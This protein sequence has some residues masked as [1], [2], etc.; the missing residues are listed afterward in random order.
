MEVANPTIIVCCRIIRIEL[1]G[2]FEIGHRHAGMTEVF[3]SNSPL[4]IGL[5]I[6]RIEPD[7]LIVVLYGAFILEKMS[8]NIGTV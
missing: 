7:S 4:V 1:D 6:V 2:F 8:I 5:S 3:M